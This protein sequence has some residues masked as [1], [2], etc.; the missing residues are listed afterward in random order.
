MPQY[1][2]IGDRKEV[3]ASCG[4][5][6]FGVIPLEGGSSSLAKATLGCKYRQAK[7]DNL[8]HELMVE[9]EGELEWSIARLND[10]SRVWTEIY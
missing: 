9:L 2:A 5:V 4:R 3:E 8:L 7:V 1:L 6:A 10:E